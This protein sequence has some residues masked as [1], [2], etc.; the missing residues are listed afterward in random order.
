MSCDDYTRRQAAK[1]AEYQHAYRAWVESLPADELR[2][3]ERQGLDAPDVAHHGNGSAR[4]DAADSQLCSENGLNKGG[5]CGWAAGIAPSAARFRGGCGG[6]AAEAR[7]GR[8][9]GRVRG[10]A[11]AWRPCHPGTPKPGKAE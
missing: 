8:G 1:D 10:G 5:R 9:G 4:G 11:A 2:E 3:L 7:R 6:G